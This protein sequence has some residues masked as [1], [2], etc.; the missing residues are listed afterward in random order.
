MVTEKT[1]AAVDELKELEDGPLENKQKHFQYKHI[2]SAVQDNIQFSS[3]WI[4]SAG[5]RESMCFH[6]LHSGQPRA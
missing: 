2:V 6:K 5:R 3:H 4:W 1:V